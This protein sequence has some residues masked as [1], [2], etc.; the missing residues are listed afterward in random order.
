MDSETGDFKLVILVDQVC[1]CPLGPRGYK[2]R[3]IIMKL[4]TEKTQDLE[5]NLHWRRP[6]ACS[7]KYRVG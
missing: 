7:N 1:G 2:Y 6:V 4:L 5:A 3:L